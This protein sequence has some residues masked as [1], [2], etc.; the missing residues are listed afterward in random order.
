MGACHFYC[1]RRGTYGQKAGQQLRARG[2]H[3]QA[4]G[5]A[6]TDPLGQSTQ[7]GLEGPPDPGHRWGPGRPV[8]SL[9]WGLP[10][11]RRQGRDSHHALR[12]QKYQGSSGSENRKASPGSPASRTQRHAL[13]CSVSSSPPSVS[14]SEKEQFHGKDLHP[15]SFRK[16]NPVL[17]NK[18]R[19]YIHKYIQNKST[20]MQRAQFSR[21]LYF[22]L[23]SLPCF[24]DHLASIKGTTT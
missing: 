23:C 6:L 8:A 12:D 10:H 13:C 21:N 4:P 17:E 9:A 2:C 3:V 16:R 19:L 14:V 18:I 20:K 24:P 5:Q 22:L 7:V 11:S 1:S 15:E